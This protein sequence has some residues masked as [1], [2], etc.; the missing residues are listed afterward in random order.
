MKAQPT[1][2]GIEAK[3]P[4]AMAAGLIALLGKVFMENK[5]LGILTQVHCTVIDHG[6]IM[7]VE[8]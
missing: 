7:G 5:A 4:I 6:G 3:Q 8:G 1:L 2:P